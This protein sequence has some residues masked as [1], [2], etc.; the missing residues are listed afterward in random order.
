MGRAWP[1]R[2]RRARAYHEPSRRPSND[3]R[4]C[5]S[6]SNDRGHGC[7]PSWIS[8]AGAESNRTE[9]HVRRT[10]GSICRGEPRSRAIQARRI[11]SHQ[12]PGDGG[13]HIDSAG[14]PSIAAHVPSASRAFLPKSKCRCPRCSTATA[15]LQPPRPVHRRC[16]LSSVC[17]WNPFVY[18]TPFERADFGACR[19]PH[20][21]RARRG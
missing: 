20:I 7:L 8:L 19:W 10:S 16:C 3:C 17:S 11:P 9:C 6:G 12:H 15:V 13:K 2:A 14:G 4:R 5:P 21:L 18:A 1:P